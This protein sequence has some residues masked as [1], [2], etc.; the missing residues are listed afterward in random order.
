MVRKIVSEMT[1]IPVQVSL[2]EIENKA[3]LKRKVN[4]IGAL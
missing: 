1:A 2:N 3:D 4:V